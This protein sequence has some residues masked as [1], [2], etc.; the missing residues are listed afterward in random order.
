MTEII[1]IT[2][3]FCAA[4]LDELENILVIVQGEALIAWRCSCCKK[5]FS[6]LH[7]HVQATIERTLQIHFQNNRIRNYTI[8][9]L[10]A[11]GKVSMGVTA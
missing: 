9:T 2:C 5:S 7:P 11:S 6:I 10:K 8:R 1:P 4:G 3:P